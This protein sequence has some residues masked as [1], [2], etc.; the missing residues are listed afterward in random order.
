VSESKRTRPIVRKV[1]DRFVFL[2]V[3]TTQSL[4]GWQGD[5]NDEFEVIWMEAAV[6]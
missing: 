1:Q 3:V 2:V 4:S 6:A 5:M